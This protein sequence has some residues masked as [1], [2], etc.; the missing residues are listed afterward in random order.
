MINQAVVL[1][2]IGEMGGVFARGILKA[3]FTVIPVTRNMD[4][5]E[6]AG[7]YPAAEFTLMAVAEKDL[8]ACL[9]SV[10]AA[11]RDDLCLLQNE[12]LPRDWQQ[13][14]LQPTVISVWFEKKKGQ[15]VKVLMP[16]PVYGKHAQALIEALQQLNIPAWEVDDAAKMEFQLVV[17]NIYI[18]TTN[19]AGIVTQGDVSDLLATHEP[20]AKTI[21]AEV[22]Q[23][24]LW[25]CGK[26]FAFEDC[27]RYFLRAIAGD[28][29]H[30]CMGR[31]APQRLQRA[32]NMAE[33]AGLD[34][35][36]MKRIAQI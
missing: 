24:Q 14:E 9:A 10:P 23:L 22:L 13:Y 32:L 29:K 35:P 17:K 31:S 30:Q 16:S 11:W 19:I 18:L 7:Q 8:A 28:P 1:V 5:Q 34:L 6:V 2:G 21:A 27:W 3:G 33:Q 4:W 12:L 36:E 15:D 26:T 20:L 25:L